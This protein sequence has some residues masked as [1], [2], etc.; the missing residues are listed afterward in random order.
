MK[1]SYT[2]NLLLAHVESILIMCKT[3]YSI[4]YKNKTIKIEICYFQDLPNG[5]FIF[6][7]SIIFVT[8]WCDWYMWLMI[9]R[10][11]HYLTKQTMLKREMNRSFERPNFQEIFDQISLI[12]WDISVPLDTKNPQLFAPH[13]REYLLHVNVIRSYTTYQYFYI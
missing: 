1:L 3:I 2:L 6:F 12:W 4:W 13:H 8:W 5:Q 7:N 11:S 10:E 9:E